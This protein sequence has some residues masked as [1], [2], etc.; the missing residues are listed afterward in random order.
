M[1]R[2][3]GKKK[4]REGKGICKER[5]KY[6][7]RERRESQKAMKWE[8]RK[9]GRKERKEERKKESAKEIEKGK[10]KEK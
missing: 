4:K 8:G 9:E 7:E 1:R 10:K 5:N 6:I 2:R 3:E